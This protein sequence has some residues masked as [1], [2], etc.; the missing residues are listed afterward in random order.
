ITG[1]ISGT[2]TIL[3]N[4]NMRKAGQNSSFFKFSTKKNR[5]QLE[6]VDK[7]RVWLSLSNA[8]GAFKQTLLGY[9]ANATNGYDNSFDGESFDG[10]QFIDFY[11]VNEDK[12]LTIQG[13]ALPFDENDEVS[14]GF[15]S[16]IEGAF[17]IDIDEVDGL[18][19]SQDVFIEDKNTNSIKNL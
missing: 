15:S 8:K 7:H 14:L 18:F 13:R 10:N 17:S 6:V 5:K 1:R 11:S 2:G 9:V 19:A 16:T 4:N 12:N 3:F